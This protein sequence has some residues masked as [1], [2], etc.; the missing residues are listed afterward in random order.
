MK[1]VFFVFGMIDWFV[2]E[3]IEYIG[4]IGMVIWCICYFGDELNC[5]CVCMVEYIFG[6][7]VDYWCKKGYI[8]F[9][10]DGELEIMLEDGC[11]FIF[12]LGM[13]YQVGDDVEV[14]QFYIKN[15][16]R[17]FIVD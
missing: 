2:V 15:G 8:L 9:C 7:L 14:Y 5:I 16:V 3:F 1:M 13:S 17:L 10:L 12:M 6:Y 11:K 4:E